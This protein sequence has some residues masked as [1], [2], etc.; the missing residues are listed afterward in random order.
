MHEFE[1]IKNYFQKLSKKSTSA[2]NLND[3]VFFDK[4][5]RLVIS[6]DTYIEGNHFIDFR[7]PELVIKKIIRSSIS[8]L[9]CKGVKPKYY[10]ISGSGNKKS[11]SKSNLSKIS[12]SLNQEQNKYKI[13]LSGGDTV[14]SNKL[15]FTITSI[16]FA[17]DIIY[18]NKAK[19]NDDIYVSGNLGDSY[20][21]LLILKNKLK[22]NNQL[23]KYFINQY[24]MPDIQLKLIDQIKKFANT[25]IDI[26]DG[27]LAD[28]DKM[29]NNQKLSYKLFL[30]DIP[31]SNNLKKIL[32]LKKLPKINYVSNGDDYQVL[33]TASKNKRRIIQRISSNCKIKL[34]KIGSI[35]SFSK[36]SS[37]IDDKNRTIAIKNKGY[38][39]K[40]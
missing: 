23:K 37:I 32:D 34:T 22:I 5:N 8:D 11:F 35:E 30:D 38:F 4:K 1:L 17:N 31:I 18:R 24:F 13:F 21:G 19:I 12:K 7:K 29:I 15:S 9:I 3:D 16:G 6:V 20:L 28:L 33:F 40:F 25:S 10:F 36:K 26:S 2:L 39:H 14:F 27:L